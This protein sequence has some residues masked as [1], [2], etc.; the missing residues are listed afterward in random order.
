MLC[1]LHGTIFFQLNRLLGFLWLILFWLSTQCYCF[2]LL[3]QH[4]VLIH[5]FFSWA[6]SAMEAALQVC[7]FEHS[8]LFFGFM[9]TQCFGLLLGTLY[10][11][12]RLTGAFLFH[13]FLFFLG[14]QCHPCCMVLYV[15]L[16]WTIFQTSM[17]Y[18]FTIQKCFWNAVV[19]EPINIAKIH[20]SISNLKTNKYVN[21][22]QCTINLGNNVSTPI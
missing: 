21:T 16:D 10:L 8:V 9:S 6:P 15:F 13:R 18:T 19:I 7:F 12:P 5:S 20:L 17:W 4:H 3:S 14:T 22:W 11:F 2:F 1:Y